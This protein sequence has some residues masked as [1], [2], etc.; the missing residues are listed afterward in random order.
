MERGIGGEGNR[1]FLCRQ[2]VSKSTSLQ[3]LKQHRGHASGRGNHR[4]SI[5]RLLVGQ[6]LLET[7]S[8]VPSLSWG[9]EGDAG[10]ASAK[11]GIERRV[12]AAA[13]EP[14]EREVSRHIAAMPFLWLAVDERPPLDPPSQR[15]LGHA[16]ARPLVR[17]SGLWNQRHVEERHEPRF[18]DLFED[19]IAKSG[20]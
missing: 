10:R 15:W 17:A 2:S 18:L 13:E 4:G 19:L 16:S 9:V 6:A 5:F 12:L 14:V 11:M 3:R 8:R 20:E 7:G 1:G